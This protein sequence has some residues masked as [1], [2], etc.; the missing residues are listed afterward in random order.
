M[1]RVTAYTAGATTYETHWEPEQERQELLNRPVL[2][3]PSSSNAG[4]YA[5]VNGPGTG[6]ETGEITIVEEIVHVPADDVTFV[7]S[8]N[9]YTFANIPNPLLDGTILQF[10]AKAASTGPVQVRINGTDTA[11]L[12][13]A[14]NLGL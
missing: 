13:S 4:Q 5:R 1:V 8:P 6:Y 2:P 14:E 3:E 7:T 10:F 9:H 12:K 11:V